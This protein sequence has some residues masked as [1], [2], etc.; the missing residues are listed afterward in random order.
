MALHV[1]KKW[2]KHLT[3]KQALSAI[4][5]QSSYLY[6]FVFPW[7]ILFKNTKDSLSFGLFMLIDG[8]FRFSVIV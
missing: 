2:A 3:R 4:A 8:Y 5:M 6:S 7:G 1:D